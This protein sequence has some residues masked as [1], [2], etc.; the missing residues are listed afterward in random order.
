[1]SGEHCNNRDKFENNRKRH[2]EYREKYCENFKKETSDC[3]D[4]LM[5]AFESELVDVVQEKIIQSYR[6]KP[7]ISKYFLLYLTK[8]CGNIFTGIEESGGDRMVVTKEILKEETQKSCQRNGVV[9]DFKYFHAG[10]S[11]ETLVRLSVNNIT[12]YRDITT[13]HHD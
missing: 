10:F 8:K 5:T 6:I 9:C 2:K 11:D 12:I 1:M 4:E 7:E 3:V 13:N